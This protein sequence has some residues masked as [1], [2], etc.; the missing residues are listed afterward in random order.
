MYSIKTW[1]T[2]TSQPKLRTD[3]PYALAWAIATNGGYAKAQVID[4]EFDTV[5]LETRH[6]FHQETQP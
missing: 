2:Q 1:N 3:L 6:D 4:Q 5:H